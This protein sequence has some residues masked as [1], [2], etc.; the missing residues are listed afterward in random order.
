MKKTLAETIN[1]II[2]YKKNQSNQQKLLLAMVLCTVAFITCILFGLVPLDRFTGTDYFDALPISTWLLTIG[3]WLP[4][5]FHLVANTK[6]SQMSTHAILFLSLMGLSFIV[7]LISIWRIKSYDIDILHLHYSQIMRW[8]WLGAAISGLALVL[9]PAMLSHDAF[10]YAGY[11]RL[12]TIYH[13]NP[14]FVTLS[15]H[16]GD[17][18]TRIDDWNS[19]PAAYGPLWLIISAL[20]ALVAGDHPLAYILL[21]R[22]LGLSMH[23]LNTFLIAKILYTGGRTERS[24]VL[25]MLIYS[26]NPLAL[27]ESSLGAHMDTFMV[28]LMLGGLLCWIAQ[29][30]VQA[31]KP[32]SLRSYL[33]S[34]SCFTLAALIKFTALPLLCLFLV[35]LVR[36]TFYAVQDGKGGLQWY[37]ALRTA[38][39]GG[40]ISAAIILAFYIPFWIGQSPRAIINSFATPPSASSAYGSILSAIL[41]WMN[42]NRQPYPGWQGALLSLFS[43]QRTWQI[44]TLIAL[45]IVM[46]CGIIWVWRHP[47]TRTLTL[48]TTAVLGALLLVTPWFFPWYVVW[49][50]GLAA[51]SLPASDRIGRA[52][53]GATL[54]FSASA[55][56]IY[57]FRGFSPIGEW[58]GFTCLTT[59]GPPIC[60]LLVL[61]IFPR[62][63]QAV[64][65]TTQVTS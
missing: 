37:R 41:N 40:L 49:I 7:Y 38:T 60:T 36:R 65:Q 26:W 43:Q 59:V 15:I 25:A 33:P 30:K 20:G 42:V 4:L 5:D 1:P 48:A 62:K 6:Q 19:A 8:I 63:K 54:A 27:L 10:V 35:V 50:V 9:T 56:F 18:F 21:Y 22:L 12:L 55:L 17:P 61:L 13:E 39:T 51:S 32:P 47:T 57:L 64:S 53:V 45:T 11:G 14:Y 16:P 44:I 23:L 3:G 34:L 46:I 29:E 52:L 28:T 58:E 2:Y 31:T 24:I